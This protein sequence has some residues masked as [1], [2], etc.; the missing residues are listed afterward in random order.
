MSHSQLPIDWNHQ[1]YLEN[2]AYFKLEQIKKLLFFPRCRKR[3]IL[4][5]FSDEEDLKNME[6]NCG[7]CDFCLEKKNR[8]HNEDLVK[9][10]TFVLVLEAVKKYDER[11]GITAFVRMFSGSEDKRI[12][13]WGLDESKYF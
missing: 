10:S 11:F 9:I 7:T 4:E 6:E 2:E 12:I 3:F 13:E 1:Q 8:G 5:Y